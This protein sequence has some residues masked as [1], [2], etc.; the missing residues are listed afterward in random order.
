MRIIIG[1]LKL[2]AELVMTFVKASRS[3]LQLLTAPPGAL[4]LMPRALLVHQKGSATCSR[5]NVSVAT[6]Q[7]LMRLHPQPG[8][9][10][11]FSCAHC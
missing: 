9:Y 4:A 11:D 1:G 10:L 7:A 3:P 2:I 6:L 5:A 8:Q